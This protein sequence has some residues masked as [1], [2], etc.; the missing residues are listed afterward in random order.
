[1]RTRTFAL[2]GTAVAL[3]VVLAACGSTTASSPETPRPRA[4]RRPPS[5]PW[6]TGRTPTSPSPS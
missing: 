3:T 2:A 6:P 5:K 1:M 4:R